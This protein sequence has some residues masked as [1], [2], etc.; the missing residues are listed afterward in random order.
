MEIAA[1]EATTTLDNNNQ[2]NT[3]T[4][5]GSGPL[6]YTTTRTTDARADTS[7]QG[8]PPTPPSKTTC[9]MNLVQ[10]GD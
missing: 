3:T 2:P 6:A 8:W 9:P 5:T 10:D 4:Q 1:T 7:G